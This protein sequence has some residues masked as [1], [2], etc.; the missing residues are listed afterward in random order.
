MYDILNKYA[1]RQMLRV[2][3]VLPGA[4]HMLGLLH[5]A[6]GALPALLR[7]EANWKSV[8]IEY[9]PP[10]VERLWCEWFESRLYLHR[11]HPC[12]AGEAL[13]HPH[14]WPSAIKVLE[15]SYEMGIGY[16]TG[17]TA[18]PIATRLILGAGSEY[19]MTD[20][21]GWHYVRPLNAPSVSFMITGKPW[22]RMSPKSDKPLFELPPEKRREILKFFRAVYQ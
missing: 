16:G 14:P 5:S 8:F 11:I 20:P 22:A 2:G 4:K 6:E 3:G 1:R 21:D 10:F 18:P 12:N 7:D 17:T 19:E 13:F 9:H 15:G